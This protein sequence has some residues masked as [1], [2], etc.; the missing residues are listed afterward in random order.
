MSPD[1]QMEVQRSTLQLILKKQLT[2]D[3]WTQLERLA[4]QGE[5]AAVELA[6]TLMAATADA[7][8][9]KAV[10][11]LKRGLHPLLPLDR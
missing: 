9:K 8:L 10:N 1:E 5:I 11:Q 3:Q 4:R 6:R 2:S 7:E